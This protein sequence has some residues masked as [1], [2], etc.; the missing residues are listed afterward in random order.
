MSK[1]I[2]KIDKLQTQKIVLYLQFINNNNEVLY[3]ALYV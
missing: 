2:T 1:H 3:S